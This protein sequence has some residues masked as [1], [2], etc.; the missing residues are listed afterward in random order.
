[1]GGQ[2]G[3]ALTASLTPVIASHFG[4]TSSFAVAAAL[5]FIG[6]FSWFLVD[7]DPGA[8]SYARGPKRGLAPAPSDVP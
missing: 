2:L 8:E 5:A 1:M 3:G 6:A 4:W 7:L